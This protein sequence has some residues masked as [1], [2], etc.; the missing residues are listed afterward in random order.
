M[1][2][3]RS[4]I[5]SF[6]EENKKV[7]DWVGEA[8]RNNQEL[9]ALVNGEKFADFLVNQI[10]K[11]ESNQRAIARKKYSKDIRDLFSRLLKPRENVFQ[12]TGG[13]ELINIKSNTIKSQLIEILNNVHGD[14]S[15]TEYLSEYYF[16]MA[17]IDPNGLMFLEYKTKPELE[18]YP[19]Y[20]SIKD[21]RNYVCEGQK[22]KVLVFE[23]KMIKTE[24]NTFIETWRIVD[25]KTDWTVRF[26]GGIYI[27]DDTKTFKHPFGEVPAVVLSN[28]EKLGSKVRLSFIHDIVEVAKEYARDKSILT[29]YKFLNGFPIHWRYV[30]QCRD[31]TGTGKVDGK[32][33]GTCD[34]K[35]FLGKAD[36]TDMV[37]I[38]K[39]REGDP[40]IAPNLAGFIQPDLKT[41]ERYELDLDR[42]EESM[43]RTLWGTTKQKSKNETATGRF[44]DVQPVS[45]E[46][47]KYT[48]NVEWIHN[49]IAN[50][51]TNLID[52][53][54][55]KKDKL[56]YK[57]YG[58]R[59]II[60]T[61]DVILERYGKSKITSDNSTILD[62][63]LEEFVLSKYKT[64]VYMQTLMLKKI[65]IEPYVH[66]S[67]KEITE[68]LGIKEATKKIL[69]QEFWKS[70][71]TN[72][73]VEDLS[74]QLNK[75]IDERSN[76][77]S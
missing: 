45:N 3:D 5:I 62:K 57:S 64:D 56:Y 75:Y 63:L 24:S 22:I 1:I 6:L 25:E 44:I 37:N 13:S 18:I 21:I 4:S 53:A 31:C 23:P 47:N 9:K 71:D 72:L 55:G 49:Q 40:V 38:T 58:R 51:I 30:T 43:E 19:T 52:P 26:V 41:W 46:L 36:V 2:F 28:K 60:E 66:W 61:P 76:I 65:Q 8:R 20:K 12:A 34:S 69:F 48:N 16:Q 50:W 42:M 32:G 73:S 11:I 35:G 74:K 27:I 17:D 59:F 14:K 68:T 10:E 29:I 33:C 39:P 7:P 15:L 70:A 54:K 67:L 77:S